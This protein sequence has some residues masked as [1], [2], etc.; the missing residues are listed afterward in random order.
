MGLADVLVPQDQVRAAAMTLAAEIAENSPLGLISTRATMRGNLAD[1]VLK[2]T[3]HELKEQTWLRKT[4]DFK[5]GVKAT[6]ERRLPN[7]TGKR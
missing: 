2:A 1:R 7:F 6:A 5:E 4:D 3:E